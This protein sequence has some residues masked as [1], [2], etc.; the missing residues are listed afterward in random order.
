MCSCMAAGAAGD[1]GG[2]HR[3]EDSVRNKS[4]R[5]PYDGVKCACADQSALEDAEGTT[6]PS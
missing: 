1:D 3:G 6:N 2:R 5:V 4:V